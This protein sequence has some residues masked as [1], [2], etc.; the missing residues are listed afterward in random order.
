[1][2]HFGVQN[3]PFQRAKWLILECKMTHFEKRA[4]FFLDFEWIFWQIRSVRLP[5]MKENPY[6]IFRL[7]I[8]T[9]RMVSKTA[10]IKKTAAAGYKCKGIASLYIIGIHV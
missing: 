9:K 10:L 6:T 5:R 3:A 1:M 4:R 8:F 2:A 7:R